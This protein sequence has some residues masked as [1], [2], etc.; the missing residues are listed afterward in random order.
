MDALEGMLTIILAG[1]LTG[2][3]RSRRADYGPFALTL[4]GTLK[5]LIIAEH[6]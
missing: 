1:G 5:H 4:S 3:H 6:R 2:P